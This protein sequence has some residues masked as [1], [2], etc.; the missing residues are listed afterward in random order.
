MANENS[1]I[2]HAY[3]VKGI[4]GD[5]TRMGAPVVQ[6][7]LVVTPSNQEVAGGVMIANGTLGGSYSGKVTGALHAAGLGEYTQ[8]IALTGNIYPDGPMP[9]VLPF[10][11]HM[12]VDARWNGIGGFHYP[13]VHVDD[14]PV[15]D[16]A[17]AASAR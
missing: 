13:G 10:Q 15:R 6:F 14:A 16:L 9:I 12:A 7:A 3:L 1:S 2:A 17:P 5:T 11:A 4:I 8:I